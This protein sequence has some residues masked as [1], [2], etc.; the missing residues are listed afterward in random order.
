MERLLNAVE[1]SAFVFGPAIIFL[2]FLW[3]AESLLEWSERRLGRRESHAK[4]L[5][6]VGNQLITPRSVDELEARRLESMFS[7]GP[8]SPS[9]FEVRSVR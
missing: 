7:E 3:A 8:I 4:F 2:A 5:V 9:V 1:V 6:Y